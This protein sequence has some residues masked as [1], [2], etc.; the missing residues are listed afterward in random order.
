MSPSPH[1]LEHTL[2]LPH[3]P[4]QSTG[5]SHGLVLHDL[6]CRE[7]CEASQALPPGPACC[8][9]EYTRVCVPDPHCNEQSLQLDQEPL[10][11][12]EGSNKF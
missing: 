10:Q 11:S 8:D 3:E 6:C 9:T 1:V 5:T 2:Q 7:A 12:K 4:E